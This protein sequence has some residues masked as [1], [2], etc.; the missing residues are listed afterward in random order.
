MRKTHDIF[1][2]KSQEK[3]PPGRTRHRLE[4]DFKVE[5]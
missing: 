1:I 2:G 4:E 5:L 3:K